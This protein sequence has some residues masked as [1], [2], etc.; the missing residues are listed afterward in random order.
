LDNFIEGLYDRFF[1]KEVS[2]KRVHLALYDVLSDEV[3]I[4]PVLLKRG[5]GGDGL[6]GCQFLQ[7]QLFKFPHDLKERRRFLLSK[8]K[9]RVHK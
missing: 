3:S 5:W 7:G 4:K 6:V 1:D 8:H 2:D 9:E